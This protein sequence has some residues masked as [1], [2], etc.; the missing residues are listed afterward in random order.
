MSRLPR[1]LLILLVLFIAL[2]ALY[3][4]TTPLFEA[5]DELW[6]YPHVWWIANGNG[7]PVQDPTQ[8]QLWEQE[9][10]QPPLYYALSAAATFWIDTRDLPE[11]L[12]RNP[13]ARIGVPLAYGNKNL[14]VHTPAENFPWQGSVLAVHLIRL[15]SVLFSAGTVLFTYRLAELVPLPIGSPATPKPIALSPASSLIPLLAAAVVAFNPMFLFISAS[16]NNDSLAALLA[17]VGLYLIVRLA[18]QGVSNGRLVGVGVVA[19]LALLAKVSNLAITMVALTVIAWLAW[20]AQSWRLLLKGAVLVLLPVALIAGWWF[21]RNWLLYGDP[22]AFNVWVQIA[23]GR[24]PQSLM[25]LVGEFQGFRISFWGNFGGV[26]LIAPEWIYNLLDL[27][28]VLAVIGLMVG[29]LAA[30]MRH[31]QPAPRASVPTAPRRPAALGLPPLLWIL[32][33]DA[34]IVFVALVRWTLLTYASQGRLMFPAIAS[35]SILGVYGLFTVGALLNSVLEGLRRKPKNA[36]T[37]AQGGGVWSALR[38]AP[39][40]YALP[41][42]LVIALLGFALLA[43]FLLIAPAYAAPPRLADVTQVPN[44]VHIRFDAGDAQPEL[45]GF[46]TTA[47]LPQG[48]KLPLTL[49]WRTDKPIAANLAMYAHVYDA[50]GNLLGQWDA[51]PGNGN[52]PTPLWQPGEIIVDH[53]E[54]PLETPVQDPPIGRI[55][56][57][58]TRAGTYLPL[59]ARNPSGQE[60][61]PMLGAFKFAQLPGQPADALATFGDQFRLVEIGLEAERAEQQIRFDTSATAPVRLKAGDVLHV[62]ANLQAQRPPDSAYVLFAHLVDGSGKIVTQDDQQPYGGAYPT[63]MWDAYERVGTTLTLTVPPDTP[64]GDYRLEYG[65]YR[66]DN[67]QRLPVTGDNWGIWRVEPDHLVATPLTVAP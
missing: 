30:L 57:G 49:Y 48:K 38:A 55:E 16:V 17:T 19:G 1:P 44:P 3:S 20:R 28:T 10:G 63:T 64:A 45:V 67:L 56:V 2:G 14:I 23:G 11:R 9:G 29:A 7:L 53:Y 31:F 50:A 61:T 6:H 36:E 32:A 35:L 13:Y 15:L 27:F 65:M 25:G 58:L 51:L 52:M 37:A 47:V 22:M 62:L 54:I 59:V 34:A 26:N 18:V 43:P 12:W 5:G 40:A 8:K 41:T 33:L 21:A 66:D 46:E 24:P 60:I 4:V 42:A 39:I